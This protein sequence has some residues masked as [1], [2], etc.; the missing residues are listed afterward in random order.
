MIGFSESAKRA[1]FR[2]VFEHVASLDHIVISGLGVL[3]AFSPL[4]IGAVNPW[5]Y[6][7]AQALIF[8]LTAVWM[9]R[10]VLAEE[11]PRLRPAGALAIPAGLFLALVLFQ[12]VPLPP[13]AEAL[14]SPSTYRLY[15]ESLPGWPGH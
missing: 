15:Q 6:G 5:A 11:G 13:K 1:L 9:V 4:A 7:A 10:I 12:L 3:L 2:I 14:L 8:C